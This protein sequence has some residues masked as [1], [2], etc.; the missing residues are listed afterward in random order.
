MAVLTNFP[1]NDNDQISVIEIFNGLMRQWDD[2][3][4]S[5][6]AVLREPI[7]PDAGFQRIV[8]PIRMTKSG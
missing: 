5:M 2:A 6:E 8:G 7:R 4:A 1:L 3:A